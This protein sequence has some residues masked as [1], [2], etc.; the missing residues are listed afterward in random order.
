M[1]N[2]RPHGMLLPTLRR[3]VA[4]SA[5][6]LAAPA[7]ACTCASQS[8][9]LSAVQA[10]GFS[11]NFGARFEAVFHGR[12]TRVVS[13]TEAQVEVLESFLGASGVKRLVSSGSTEDCGV[14]FLLGEEYIFMPLKGGYV[15]WCW[16]LSASPQ[17]LAALRVEYK[18]KRNFIKLLDT[19]EGL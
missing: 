12:V 10:H 2:V 4:L 6:F 11:P 13:P 18:R 1:S 16:R 3:L 5:V 9:F 7:L 8:R 17:N 14:S 15:I 19:I